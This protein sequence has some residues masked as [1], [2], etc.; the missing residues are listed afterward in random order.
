M[1]DEPIP[2]DFLASGHLDSAVRRLGMDLIGTSIGVYQITSLPGV[3]IGRPSVRAPA[4]RSSSTT[5][6]ALSQR[7]IAV[8]VVTFKILKAA[9]LFTAP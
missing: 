5:G 3:G 2:S 4:S 8:S 1:S 9:E 6:S 7:F